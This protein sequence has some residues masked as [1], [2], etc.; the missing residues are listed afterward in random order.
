[1]TDEH[2]VQMNK[3]RLEAFTILYMLLAMI[4]KKATF[5]DGDTTYSRPWEDCY[6]EVTST[7]EEL[8]GMSLGEKY[9]AFL[10][11][12]GH[13]DLESTWYELNQMMHLRP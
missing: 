11:R 6:L 5:G 4:V 10:E 2:I 1:M 8:Q 13:P 7:I 9:Y 12:P 3:A